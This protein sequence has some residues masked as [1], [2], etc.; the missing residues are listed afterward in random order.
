MS[1]IYIVSAINYNF[2]SLD[3]SNFAKSEIVYGYFSNLK[4]IHLLLKGK[5]VQ[6]YS[7]IAKKLNKRKS[8]VIENV[9]IKTEFGKLK[10]NHLL[11]RTVNINE[12]YGFTKQ[13]N[14]S[15]LISSDVFRNDI[16]LILS[17]NMP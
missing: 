6:A 2:K 3:K 12:L 5:N 1:P 10:V 8:V 16:G 14:L 7:T 17:D 4:Q 11:I 9:I 13:V 15:I